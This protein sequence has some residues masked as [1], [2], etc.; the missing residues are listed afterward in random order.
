VRLRVNP[1]TV[2]R[3]R[4]EGDGSLIIGANVRDGR[5]GSGCCGDS[6]LTVYARWARP[7][8]HERADEQDR[9]DEWQ[10]EDRRQQAED[11]ER[12]EHEPHRGEREREQRQQEDAEPSGEVGDLVQERGQGLW[13]AGRVHGIWT[14]QPAGM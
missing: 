9:R 7:S 14:L 5:V 6:E 4:R 10:R 13:G 8:A 2:R 12:H 1:A 11:A 3:F